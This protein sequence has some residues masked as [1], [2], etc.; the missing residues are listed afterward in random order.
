MDFNDISNVNEIYIQIIK[1]KR[2][3]Q[4]AFCF[5]DKAY[6]FGDLDNNVNLTI[7]KLAA[8]GVKP[9]TVVGYTFPNCPEVIYL[10]I[11]LSRMGAITVPLFHMIPD[12]GKMGIFTKSRAEF[13]I[14]S[15][16]MIDGLADARMK[17]SA[18]VKLVTIEKSEKADFSF[19]T[20]DDSQVVLEKHVLPQIQPQ[21]P[22]MIASSSGT[23]GVPKPI[24][25]T[26][27]NVASTLKASMVL[28]TPVQFNEYNE[29]MMVMAFPL[30][31]SGLIVCLGTMF[32]GATIVFSDD[33]SPVKFME[34]ITKW[35]ASA[36]A[37]P[38]AYFENIL[39]LPMLDSFK[40]TS[41]KAVLSGMDFFS[42]S[43][44]KRLRLKFTNIKKAGNGYG[45]M[46]TSLVF[47]VWRNKNEEE[48]NGATSTLSLVENI[49][50]MIDVRDEN[51]RS[52]ECGADGDLWVKGKSVID[53]YP[54]NPEESQKAF[55]DG[56]FKTGD[57]ARKESNTNITLLGRNK[58]LIKR[59][60]KTVSPIV[61]QNHL[62]KCAGVVSSAVVGV[63][64]SLYGE[65]VWA[66]VVRKSVLD[67]T[68]KD[69]MK[70]C[71][72]ELP[73]Y[74]VP[75]QIV[76]VDDIPKNPGVGKLDY[77]KMKQIANEGLKIMEVSQ[78]G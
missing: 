45:L 9:G 14:T 1:Q 48:L 3:E 8:I 27:E 37:A 58:Y 18:G 47:M 35:N 29:S 5:N 39:L 78:N 30:C 64:H 25:L 34:L 75:D 52:V 15:G 76:F 16:K 43:L 59:G 49:G 41:I 2:P 65:M 55:I 61:I 50:N 32:A 57:F 31:T 42:P 71:R 26:Q 12:M 66:F 74:M 20:I 72:A 36:M 7:K 4:I 11:G 53:G 13:I 77:E 17:M 44:L 63:P 70:H 51:N 19:A 73:P 62:N 60:G 33:M 38:P 46:E 24:L 54:G 23:T 22:M 69:I 21:H 40:L 68:L 67:A 6:S 10:L 56:W 28:S